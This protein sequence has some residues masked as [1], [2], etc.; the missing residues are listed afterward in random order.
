M[1]RRTKGGREIR[2][3][4]DFKKLIIFK[5]KEKE[6]WEK[7][8]KKK[9]IISS[10]RWYFIAGPV[11]RRERRNIMCAME[12][13]RWNIDAHFGNVREIWRSV[14]ASSQWRRRRA[15]VKPGERRGATTE[16][17]RREESGE[18]NARENQWGRLYR[19]KPL[20]RV[21]PEPAPRPSF[22]Q[23]VRSTPLNIITRL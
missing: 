14:S 6:K 21:G 10:F 9:Q 18:R 16:T 4:R 11:K 2:Y 13:R 12:T 23:F 20:S 7:K 8:Q 22:P 1:W 5:A 3:K 15:P 19:E 17:R